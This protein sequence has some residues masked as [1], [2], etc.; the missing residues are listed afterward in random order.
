VLETACL[1]IL[2]GRHR[3]RYYIVVKVGE[4]VSTFQHELAASRPFTSEPLL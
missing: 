3:L 2:A 4:K 1:Y